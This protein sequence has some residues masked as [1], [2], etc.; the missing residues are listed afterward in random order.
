[1]HSNR[2]NPTAFSIHAKRRNNV[3]SKGHFNGKLGSKGG[4]KGKC[5]V[6]D[7]FG[8]YARE[9]PNRRDTSHDDDHNQRNGRYNGK[10]KRN[11]RSRK[12]STLQ[13]SKEL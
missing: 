5:F 4:M 7:K 9:F 12:C 13:E 3:A 1:M 2:S 11:F 8:H 10:G 6:C